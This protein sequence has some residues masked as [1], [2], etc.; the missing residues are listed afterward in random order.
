MFVGMVQVT[1]QCAVSA[2]KDMYLDMYLDLLGRWPL[3]ALIVCDHIEKYR[4]G[5]FSDV[6]YVGGHVNTPKGVVT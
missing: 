5:W 6:A 1:C 4:F 3:A 2:A